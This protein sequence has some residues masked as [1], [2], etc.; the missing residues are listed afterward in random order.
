MGVNASMSYSAGRQYSVLVGDTIG[1]RLDRTVAA[2]PDGLALVSCHQDIR[3]TWSEFDASV[4]SAARA[5]LAFGI[6]KGER[7]GVW[8]PT[9]AEWAHLQLAAARVGAILVVVNPAYQR[10]E[11]AYALRHSG[12]RLLVTAEAF[13]GSDYLMML[14]A[15]RDRL[16]GLERVVVLGDRLGDRVGDQ[17]WSQFLA[18]GEHVTSDAVRERELAN[19][20]DDPIN[21]QYTS[22][23]TG[24]PKGATLTHHNILNNAIAIAELL[25][26]SNADRVAIPLPLYHCFG[27]GIGNLGCVAAGAAMVYPAASFD[28]EATLEAIA[29]ERCTSIYGVPTM[30]I[31]ELEHPRFA[32]FDLSSLRTG[33]MGGAPCPVEVMKRV[34]SD[35]HASEICIVYGMTETSPVSFVTRPDDEIE[36]RV[37]TVGPV[38]SNTEAKIIDPVTGA[39]VPRGEPGEICTR[40]YLV[41]L[42]YWDNP[43]ATAEAIDGA[44]WMHTGDIGVLDDAGYLN[45]VGRIKDLVIR[46][47]ENIYPREIEEVLFT[48]PDIATA[49]VIG[50]PDVRFGEQLMAWI[51]LRDGAS[52]VD[53]QSI[54][55]FCRQRMSHFK[56]PQVVKFVDTFPMTVT[57]KVQKYKMRDMA[58]EELGLQAAAGVRTA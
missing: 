51:V 11:V 25:G 18:S 29:G 7:V 46:G 8:S 33:L 23:T 28:A 14:A 53:A 26:Y 20:P 12:V 47:G 17:T 19:D 21:I 5:L 58:I 15:V 42:G 40:G 44:G 55:D 22:G 35:M 57:G 34:I 31:A 3:Q 37:S 9:C 52:G 54:K 45:I 49:Q 56:V 24:S 10:E 50:I 30:F 4:A 2:D 39:T 41:M 36:R 16:P 32:E 48:H 27:M 13:K 38:G 6:G 1:Q 43:E